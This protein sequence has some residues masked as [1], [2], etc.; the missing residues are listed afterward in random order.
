DL[1]ATIE[2]RKK[3]EIINQALN[4]ARR[5]QGNG[6]PQG[7]L[8]ELEGALA[9]YP[10]DRRLTDLQAQLQQKME[11]AA[12]AARLDEIRRKKEAFVQ[13]ALTRAQQTAALDARIT[14][15]EEASNAEPQES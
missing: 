11:Q 10:S 2:T 3:E 6:N 13:N 5:L 12:E 7:A 15:L 9:A 1:Q 4:A 8:R 14:I